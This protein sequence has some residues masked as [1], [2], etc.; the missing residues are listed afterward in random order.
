MEPHSSPA[1]RDPLF[2]GVLLLVCGVAIWLLLMPFFPAIAAVTLR[3]FHLQGDSFAAWAVQAPIPTMYNFSNR[4]EVRDLPEGFIVPVLDT[5]KPRYI[6]HFPVR[7]FTFADGRWTLLHS[8]QD[9]WITCWSSYRGQTL[10]TKWHAK[11]I[12]E[13]RFELVRE[14]VGDE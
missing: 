7:V 3:R 13:G 10:Q 11:P 4:Y 5:T 6:N 8:G 9:R 12:S 1:K 14:E 2:V